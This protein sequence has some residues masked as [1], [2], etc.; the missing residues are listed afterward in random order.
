M[1]EDLQKQLNG[2]GMWL[3]TVEIT[4]VKICSKRLFDDM[5]AEFRQETHLKA[6]EI[7]LSTENKVLENQQNTE[8]Y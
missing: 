7:R 6:E 1:K 5:Q 2:W 3:E 4:E 8:F